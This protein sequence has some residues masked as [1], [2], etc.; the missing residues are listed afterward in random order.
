MT[1]SQFMAFLERK[2]V[3]HGVRK[4][5]PDRDTMERHACSVIEHHLASGALRDMRDRLKGQAGAVALPEDMDRRVRALLERDPSLPWDEAV[6]GVALGVAKEG[7]WPMTS[8][9]R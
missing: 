6:A 4:I 1:S 2:L 3:E 7:A 9:N 8:N 5:V